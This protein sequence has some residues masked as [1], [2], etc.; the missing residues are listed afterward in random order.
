MRN[1]ILAI[2]L[3]LS[4]TAW[5]VTYK[6]YV[7]STKASAPRSSSVTYDMPDY[8]FYSTSMFQSSQGYASSRVAQQGRVHVVA[9]QE[10]VG[11]ERTSVGAGFNILG[12]SRE[13]K[14]I[15]PQMI[16][17][18]D[19]TMRSTSSMLSSNNSNRQDPTLT[20]ISVRPIT[21]P[22]R[23]I[24]PD[25]D[26]DD[27]VEN[28]TPV[29]D[30]LLPLLLL[31]MAYA[32]WKL[33]RRAL[34]AALLGLVACTPA[35]QGNQAFDS[36]VRYSQEVINARMSCWYNK[37]KQVG[38]PNANATNGAVLPVEE[39]GWDYVPGVVAKG[40]L[41]VWEYYQDSAW[42]D[43]WYEGLCQWGLCQTAT[44]HGGVLDDLNCTKVF[45]G[46][47]QGAKPGGRFENAANAAYFRQQLCRGAKG[48]A[49]HK[50][51]YT[52]AAG[53]AAGGWMHKATD[54]PSK[55]YYGQMWC[56]GAYMGPA[57]LAQL[58]A[59]GVTD[60]AE[61]G[62]NDVYDQFT[63]S[64]PYLWDEEKQL[65]YHVL[66]TD[67]QSNRNARDIYESGHAYACANDSS[68]YHSEEYWGR[69]AGWYM[70]ALVDVLEAY[71]ES[72]KAS[73]EWHE[74]DALPSA[75]YFDILLDY[76][77]QL[78]DG[79]VARQDQQT[80]CWYQ[81]LQYGP[82]KCATQGVE[83]TGSE[84]YSN[85][86]EG[87]TQCNYLESSASCLITAALLKGTRLGLLHH[88]EAGRRG[89]EGIIRQ[90]VRGERGTYTI[91]SSC[92]SAGLSHDR[93]G[94]AAYY[95]IGKDVPIQDNTEG[96]VLGPF[97]MA[98]VEYER[99]AR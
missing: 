70:L 42:A 13:K 25:D 23:I 5:A 67:I 93:N 71:L 83:T 85:V 29:G 97:L 68:I 8:Q 56:D 75:A 57:L 16:M 7:N 94:S 55:S 50:A 72:L 91:T 11:L 48:L 3:G 4:T 34:W 2:L 63:A 9:S 47:Y 87:G 52:I 19:L 90:F 59:A 39:A 77:T 81:L 43:A 45:L 6:P 51:R 95:L 82:E 76:L 28:G 33:R 36:S 79:L 30:G 10:K 32:V 1:T 38:F 80:G 26:D 98:A 54:D 65:P 14:H 88:A 22:R 69:A 41:D 62:W 99:L 46:L 24:N 17:V 73:G 35:K 53:G 66:F 31:A 60:E 89:Y 15:T 27:D 96:K 12:N 92:Q 49:D 21:P 78:A 44:D 84:R 61:L 58:L 64:W 74:G 86:A 20:N 40:I 18:G 37:D